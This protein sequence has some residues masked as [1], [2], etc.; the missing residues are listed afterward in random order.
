M[1]SYLGMAQETATRALLALEDDG[2]ISINHR[3]VCIHDRGALLTL[4]RMPRQRCLP[5]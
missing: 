5:D 1:G 4:K 3:T 2:L